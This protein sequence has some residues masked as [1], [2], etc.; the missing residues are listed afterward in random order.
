[1]RFKVLFAAVFKD[2]KGDVWEENG[3][4]SSANRS[5]DGKHRKI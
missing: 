5:R 2:S 4:A 3:Y 1:M